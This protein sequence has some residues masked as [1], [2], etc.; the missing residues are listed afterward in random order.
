MFQK[1]MSDRIEGEFN[2]KFYGRLSILTNYRL[3]IIKKFQCFNNCFL[4]KPKVYFTIICFE[5]KNEYVIRYKR[6]KKFR[7]NYFFFISNKRK[8][9]NKSFKKIFKDLNYI[10]KIKNLDLTKDHLKNL[11]IL[12]MR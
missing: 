12:T 11:Q 6:N 9:I 10:K 2:I 8:M 7:K 3:N 5:P 1:E 4:P